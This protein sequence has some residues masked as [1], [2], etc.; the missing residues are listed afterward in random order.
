M[1]QAII[2]QASDKTLRQIKREIERDP[3]L[4][5]DNTKRGYLHDLGAFEE[6]RAGRPMT[7]LLVEEYVAKLQAETKSPNTINRVL[8][9]V[10]W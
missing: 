6:W 9:S 4:K 3:Q 7:K 10:R 8:A 1:K 2:T 5:S